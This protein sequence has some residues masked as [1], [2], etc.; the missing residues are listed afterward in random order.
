MKITAISPLLVNVSAK[1]NWFFLQVETDAG[2]QGLGEATLSGSW[3]TVQLACLERLRPH[4]VGKSPDVAV[5]ALQVYPHSPGGLA[6][7][8]IMSAVEIALTDIRAREAGVPVHALF[9]QPRNESMRIYANVNRMTYDR[10]PAGFARSAQAKI[11][12]GYTAVKMAPFDNVYYTDLEDGTVRARLRLGIDCVLAVRDAIGPAVDLMIDC[13]WRFDEKTA[14]EV[15]RELEPAK[16]FW[17]ECM[18]SERAEHHAELARVRAFARERGV[19]LAGA[20]RQVGA[21]GLEP[22]VRAGLLDVVMPDIKYSG[23]C[24]EMQRIAERAAQGGIALSPHNPTGPVCTFAS[25]HMCSLA[26]NFLILEHQTE[27]TLYRDIINEPHP[28]PRDGAFP[29]PRGPGLG[30]TLNMD[31]VRERPYRTPT[32]E[33]LSDPRLS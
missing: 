6:A 16:L 20:E 30:V 2:I 1:T 25:L 5:A 9:G 11:A 19:R 31:V 26:S 14:C 27:G 32:A 3:E 17:A 29:V 28:L 22:I 23:G 12:E 33:A 18:V 4:V 8:S 15:L 10:S 7:N 13:H 24:R 21:M